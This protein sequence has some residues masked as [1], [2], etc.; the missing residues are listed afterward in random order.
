MTGICASAGVALVFIP[1]VPR[2]QVS[3]AVKWL[4]PSK[5]MIGLSLLGRFEDR[6]WFTFFHEVCH[7]L[8]HQKKLVFLDNE[9]GACDDTDEAEADR[10]A[11]DVLISR[12]VL[13][14]LA[15]VRHTNEAVTAFAERIGVSPGSWSGGCSTKGGCRGV[16]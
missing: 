15:F 6:F 5:A 1:A 2:S 11:A 7:V 10:F 13:A 3:G 8:K 9:G 14:E 12:A 4:S 16:T